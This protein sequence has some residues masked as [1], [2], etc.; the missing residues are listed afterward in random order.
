MTSGALKYDRKV[1]RTKNIEDCLSCLPIRLK[2][3]GDILCGTPRSEENI[4]NDIFFAL[5]TNW[6]KVSFRTKGH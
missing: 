6:G 2:V 3:I 5:K 1:I 4:R